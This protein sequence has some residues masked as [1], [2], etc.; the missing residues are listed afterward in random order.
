MADRS[1]RPTLRFRP[2]GRF[3]IAQFTDL[4][5]NNGEPED[6]RTRALMEAVLAAEQPDL[7]VL[8]GDVLEGKRCRNPAASW[9][10]AVGPLEERGVPWAAVFGNHDD[11]GPLDRAEL[12]AVQRESAHCL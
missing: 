12:M 7:A 4:H 8:T 5:W 1:L 10:E 2:D 3:V 6:L 9:R 11:E